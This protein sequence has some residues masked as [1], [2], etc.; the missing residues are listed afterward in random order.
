MIY[1]SHLI[2]NFVEPVTNFYRTAKSQ[3]HDNID[4]FLNNMDKYI[5]IFFLDILIYFRNQH[6]QTWIAAISD[7]MQ[8][9]CSLFLTIFNLLEMFLYAWA[10]TTVISCKPNSL[11]F[12][13]SN[14]YQL[15]NSK[16][17][18]KIPYFFKR[19]FWNFKPF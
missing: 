8:S 9:L 16:M 11:L 17:L 4:Y 2:F 10:S 5:I 13:F 19:N 3:P 15:P 12:Y 1:F 7:K 14:E 6:Q 18:L